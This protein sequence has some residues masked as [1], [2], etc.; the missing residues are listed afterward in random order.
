[1]DAADVDL[2]DP[3]TQ[4]DPFEAYRHLRDHAPV[5]RVPGTS[6]YVVTRYHDIVHVLRHQDVFPTGT[7]RF[8]SPR[9]VQVL[10]DHATSL[11][12]PLSSNPPE[13]RHYRAL[14]DPFFSGRGAERWADLIDSTITE[15][16]DSMAPLGRCEFV[17]A[18]AEPLPV[19]VITR[20]L[21]FPETDIAQLTA[22]SSAW[23]LPF[24][25][26]LSE[27]DEVWVAQ[28]MVEFR[29][30]IA[31]HVQ[32]RRARPG[33]EVISALTQARYA[34]ERALTDDEIITIVDHLYIG[35]NE[36]TTFALTSAMWLMLREPAVYQRLLADR[37]LI[38][39]FVEEVLRLE[40]PTQGL[41]RRAAVDTEIAGVPIPAG[42]AVHLRY[43]AGNR[44]ERVFTDP[45]RLDL[46]RPN[47]RRH[48][49]FGLGEHHCPGE[50]LSRLEQRRAIAA[51]V[52]RLANLALGPGN[53]F[54]HQPGFVLRAL[55]ALH[56]TWDPEPGRAP[57]G[58][59]R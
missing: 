26:G 8:R 6:M 18:F 15:L 1:M 58:T 35:G 29:R 23:V 31:E 36:T 12:T 22:W 9:A 40:S 59:G 54:G 19:R 41:Y 51:I 39:C 32:A 42:S 49:A 33:D 57:E 5:Y 10:T 38:P 28:Q 48:L 2:F 53:T 47:V 56:L 3:V 52:D 7:G 45:D 43:G 44:D 25:G 17:S 27:D 21:G 13:H 16:L 34:D 46:E 30:Y 55:E 37:S 20:I 24:A 4:N 50:G 11:A 14:V